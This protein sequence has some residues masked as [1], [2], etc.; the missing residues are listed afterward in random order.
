MGGSY[1]IDSNNLL[2]LFPV[3]VVHNL[4]H[5]AV[6]VAGLAAYAQG[7][8]AP[9]VFA[10]GVGGVYALL[11]VLGLLV[12]GSGNFLGIMPIGGLDIALHGVTA[13]TLLYVGFAVQDSPTAVHA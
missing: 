8:T 7:T 9:R 13:A 2:G 12:A 3:N 1:G 5:M 10:R 6:G 11:T 4:V